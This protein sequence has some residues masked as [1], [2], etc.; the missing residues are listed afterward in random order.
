MEFDYTNYRIQFVKQALHEELNFFENHALTKMHA[1]CEYKSYLQVRLGLDP[2]SLH[3]S[4]RNNNHK[5]HVEDYLNDVES[6]VYRKP[7]TKL[8][9]CHKIIKMQEFINQLDHDVDKDMMSKI[10][11]LLSAKAQISKQLGIKYD[12]NTMRITEVDA[13]VYSPVSK[14][15]ILRS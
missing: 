15:Y 7:W 10:T 3:Y 2:V 6:T 14:K 9:L 11:T 4:Q 1:I 13:I 8:R 12:A 5:L